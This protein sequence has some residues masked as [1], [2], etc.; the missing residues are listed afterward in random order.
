MPDHRISAHDA[1]LVSEAIDRLAPRWTTWTLQTIA[2]HGQMRFAKI[3]AAL[4][5]LSTQNTQQIMRRMHTNGLLD[6]PEYGVY[7]VSALGRTAHNAHGA[8]ASWHRTHSGGSSSA[9]AEAERT[10]DAL[11]RLRGEGAID[12]LHALSE[13][14]P[15]PNGELRKASGLATGSFYYR[16]QQL[17]EDQLLTR[18]GPSSRAAYTL[19]PAAQALGPIYAELAAFESLTPSV[20]VQHKPT[21]LA[22]A[23]TARADA[24]VRRTPSGFPGLFSHAPAAQ[25]R[26]PAHVT[27]LSHPSRTR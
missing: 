15:L 6:W 5:W 27:A 25:P 13:H 1:K 10:E 8:L 19:T 26:V 14:G 12:V 7:E 20:T 16:L 2:Q 18:T 24:A 22:S 21:A 4:P 9:V 11:R 3:A 23:S 17:Q